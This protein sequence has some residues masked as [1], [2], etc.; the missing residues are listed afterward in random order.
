[1]SNPFLKELRAFNPTTDLEVDEGFG[2]IETNPL[3]SLTSQ[4]DGGTE[5]I[6]DFVIKEVISLKTGDAIAASPVLLPDGKVLIANRRGDVLILAVE[7]KILVKVLTVNLK[8][9]VLRKPALVGSTLYF[10]GRDGTL[11]AVSY[12]SDPA[13]ALKPLWK[14]KLPK[15]VLAEPVASGKILFVSSMGGLYAFDAYADGSENPDTGRKLWLFESGVSVATPTIEGGVLFLG[16]EEGQ[17]HAVEYGGSS[18]QDIWVYAASSPIRSTPFVSR[19]T[20]YVLFGTQD[21]NLEALD[22]H[23]S[24]KRWFVYMEAPVYGGIAALDMNGQEHYFA[25]SDKGVFYCIDTFGKK[26]WSFRTNGKIR[27]EPVIIGNAVIFGSGDNQLYGLD[28][29]T[30]KQL[31]RYVTDG[32]I[33]GTPLYTGGLLLFGSAD[34]FV[35]AIDLSKVSAIHLPQESSHAI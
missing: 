1:M 24:E 15:G 31:F 28:V 18:V 10:A 3:D 21:G 5:K 20:D 29:E 2:K 30:G 33:I 19:R 8:T 11:L 23:S 26:K 22:R 35:H 32:D 7:N 27:S 14:K 13:P 9:V 34:S 12:S 6:A 4:G 17:L 25:G 16:N